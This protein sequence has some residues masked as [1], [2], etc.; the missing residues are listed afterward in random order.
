MQAALIYAPGVAL[1]A[2]GWASSW[3]R[4][5]PG[6]G[7]RRLAYGN[8]TRLG[9][10]AWGQGCWRDGSMCESVAGGGGRGVGFGPAGTPNRS[11][12]S[13]KGPPELLRALRNGWRSAL[14]ATGGWA[15]APCCAGGS[16]AVEC[17][18]LGSGRNRLGHGRRPRMAAVDPPGSAKATCN[19]RPWWRARGGRGA[20]GMGVV[21]PVGE[22]LVFRH[23]AAG[24]SLG[25]HWQTSPW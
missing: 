17:G 25:R 21:A 10:L 16:R 23:G 6:W 4:G 15:W 19:G 2:V 1:L 9:A 3:F 11:A 14:F 7:R 13:G 8:P 18:V 24:S 12:A 22:V 5:L 20:Y